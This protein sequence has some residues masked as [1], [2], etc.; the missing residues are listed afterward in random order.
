LEGIGTLGRLGDLLRSDNPL[1][2][3]S[4]VASYSSYSPD[5]LAPFG[6]PPSHTDVF[7]PSSALTQPA[8]PMTSTSTSTLPGVF[9]PDEFC[10]FPSLPA[11][12]AVKPPAVPFQTLAPGLDC[13]INAGLN[14]QQAAVN[15]PLGDW[16]IDFNFES[17]TGSNDAISDWD[18]F[19][20]GLDFQDHSPASDPSSPAS[21]TTRTRSTSHSAYPNTSSLASSN[22]SSSPAP[23]DLRNPGTGMGELFSCRQCRKTFGD[24]VKL[25]LHIR[26]HGERKYRC[27]IAGCDKR[28]KT[29]EV[30]KRHEQTIAHGNQ[31]RFRCSRCPKAYGRK[32]NLQKHERMVH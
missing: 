19:A 24:R 5:L 31:T 28:F 18:Q 2:V 15:P 26:S 21:D 8:L 14:C 7:D 12:A 22:C 9:Y 6:A 17:L 30:Q 16:D 3:G 23:E 20:R 27:S 13:A 10:L 4:V 25:H 11:A 29:K 32:D 1:S